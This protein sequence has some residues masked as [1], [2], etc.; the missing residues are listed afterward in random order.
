MNKSFLSSALVTTVVLFVLNAIV[1][2]VFLKDFFQNHPAVSPEFMKQLYRPDDQ[3]IVWALLICTI[4]IGVFVTKVIQWSGART[5]VAGLKSGFV[6][7][8]LFLFS[9]DF[10]LLATTNNFA[11]AGAFADMTCSTIAITLSSAVSACM[12]GRGTQS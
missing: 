12:L 3:I 6:F 9:V 1:Y 11:T 2:M 5:F 8:I 7:G 4:S 10:G